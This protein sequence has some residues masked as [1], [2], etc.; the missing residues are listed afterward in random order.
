MEILK[1]AIPLLTFALGFV[2]NRWLD[3]RKSRKQIMREAA[4]N[5]VTYLNEWQD[6]II[7]L[8]QGIAKVKS[9]DEL[10]VIV[11][12]YHAR[13]S[14]VSKIALEIGILRRFREASRLVSAILEIARWNNRGAWLPHGAEIEWNE[15]NVVHGI[16]MTLS[17]EENMR[18]GELTEAI[19][20]YSYP[21]FESSVV[22]STKSSVVRFYAEFM[23]RLTNVTNEAAHL[24]SKLK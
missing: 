15:L 8:S 16:D 14:I 23:I 19:Q 6:L 1:I 22:E 21:D 5:A 13:R 7:E 17:M 2:L 12:R 20:R 4:L 3:S 10:S 18:L 11:S 24:V 9:S